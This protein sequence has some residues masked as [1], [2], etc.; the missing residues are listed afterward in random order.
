MEEYGEHYYLEYEEIILAKGEATDQHKV[1]VSS[2]MDKIG[3]YPEENPLITISS[4]DSK[5]FGLQILD[6]IL[7]YEKH[8]NSNLQ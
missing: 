3:I 1:F 6:V 7:E 5:T 4:M 2:Y 8:L